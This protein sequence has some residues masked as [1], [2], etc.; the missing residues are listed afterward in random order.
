MGLADAMKV[1]NPNR[2]GKQVHFAQDPGFEVNAVQVLGTGLMGG[3][4]GY[5]INA[6][7]GKVSGDFLNSCHIH[8]IY[9][10]LCSRPQSKVLSHE[11]LIYKMAQ[12]MSESGTS[13]WHVILA[14]KRD[15]S[16]SDLLHRLGLSLKS[17]LLPKS[18]I[19]SKNFYTITGSSKLNKM[20][21]SN[22]G[23]CLRASWI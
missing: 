11:N 1:E 14:Q 7:Q 12:V 3:T 22:T 6:V 13:N 17:S 19:T 9:D 16:P 15:M 8:G 18:R 4:H 21:A 10:H 20:I 2:K 23:P 5:D